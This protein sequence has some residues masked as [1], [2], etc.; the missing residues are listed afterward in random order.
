MLICHVYAVDARLPA[1][2]ITP[3]AAFITYA[4][5]YAMLRLLRHAYDID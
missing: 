1:A 4:A 3:F 2:D 5:D